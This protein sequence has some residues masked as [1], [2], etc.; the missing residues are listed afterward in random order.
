VAFFDDMGNKR[1]EPEPGGTLEIRSV[2]LPIVGSKSNH[3]V[4]AL[5][6]RKFLELPPSGAPPNARLIG[7]RFYVA[8]DADHHVWQHF[9]LRTGEAGKTCEGN[10]LGFYYIASDGEVA[11]ALGD[12]TP[13]QGIDLATCDTLWSLPGPAPNEAKEVWKVHTTL[14]QRTNDRLFSLVAPQR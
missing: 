10:S 3:R 9:D 8:T 13:A 7:S 1:G 11:V 12:G 2:D 5:D 4:F 6:G 14:I